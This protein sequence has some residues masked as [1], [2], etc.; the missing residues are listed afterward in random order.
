MTPALT[1]WIGWLFAVGSLCFFVAS[2]ASQWD[3]TPRTAIGVTFFAGSILF[4]GAGYL[5]HHGSVREVVTGDPLKGSG[6]RPHRPGTWSRKHADVLASLIQLVG[7]ILFNVNTFDALQANLDATQADL[8]VWTPDAIGSV[9]FLVS[10]QIAFSNVSRAW[11]AFRWRDRDWQVAAANLLG[12][13]AFAVAAVASLVVPDTDAALS[14]TLA[15]AGTA[16]GAVGFLA[17]ALLMLAPPARRDAA[18]AAAPAG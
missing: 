7:T 5:Q 10:S 17:G 3:D 14:Q 15:N 8:R 1:R 2:V 9:C 12:A 13:I 11:V 16:A 4:T 18:H 6:T